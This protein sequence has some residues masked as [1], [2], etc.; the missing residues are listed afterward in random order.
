MCE[1]RDEIRRDTRSNNGEGNFAKRE[2]HRR[3]EFEEATIEEHVWMMVRICV[4]Q[5][6]VCAACRVVRCSLLVRVMFSS[7][8]SGSIFVTNSVIALCH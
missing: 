7:C 1:R 3:A 8:E 2:H 6:I 5:I 4:N